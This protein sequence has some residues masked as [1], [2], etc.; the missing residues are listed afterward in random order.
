MK[1]GILLCYLQNHAKS[2]T[3][4]FPS[5]GECIDKTGHTLASVVHHCHGTID[6][7]IL[8]SGQTNLHVVMGTNLK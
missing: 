1:K 3:F 2:F 4:R 7:Y 6:T 5:F 8:T